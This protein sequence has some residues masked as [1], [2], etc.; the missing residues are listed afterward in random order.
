[1]ARAESEPISAADRADRGTSTRTV[2]AVVGLGAPLLAVLLAIL[3]IG[4][5]YGIVDDAIAFGL[6]ESVHS[7]GF[8]HAYWHQVWSDASGVMVRE[9][10]HPL[11]YLVF[12]HCRPFYEFLITP[13]SP[14]LGHAVTMVPSCPTMT[15]VCTPSRTPS[16][17]HLSPS[18]CG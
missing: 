18:G 10:S 6:V 15:V 11:D 3:L 1:M 13:G 2:P 16:A 17:R 9:R 5:Y 14:S 4:P 8:L 7:H 12:A